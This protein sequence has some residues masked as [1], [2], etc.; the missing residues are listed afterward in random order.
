L[1]WPVPHW[2]LRISSTTG[3]ALRTDIGD[4]ALSERGASLTIR[5]GHE[6]DLPNLL[7]HPSVQHGRNLV[8]AVQEQLTCKQRMSGGDGSMQQLMVGAILA[9]LSGPHAVPEWRPEPEEHNVTRMVFT[10][11]RILPPVYVA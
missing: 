2:D 10:Q 5:A 6:Y 4:L 11:K 9:P 1:P 7:L 3:C 8:N